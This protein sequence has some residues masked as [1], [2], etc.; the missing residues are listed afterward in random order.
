VLNN[1]GYSASLVFG[2][3]LILYFIISYPL[4]RFGARMEKKLALSNH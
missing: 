2:T 3:I 1:K 4:A